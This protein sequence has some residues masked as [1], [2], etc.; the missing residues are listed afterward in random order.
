M[1]RKLLLADDSVTIQKVVE[2]ILSEDDFAITTVSDG[3]E[4][5]ARM[6]DVKPDIVLADVDMPK[7]GG[8]ELCKKIKADPATRHI[9]VLLLAGAFE[10]IDA[11]KVKEAGAVDY[12]VKPFESQDLINKIEG[13]FGKLSGG[14]EEAIE[15]GPQQAAKGKSKAPVEETV[16]EENK[17]SI[18]MGRMDSGFLDEGQ[19]LGF[20]DSH[21][22]TREL[23][24]VLSSIS[25]E[26]EA[27]PKGE[28]VEELED[29]EELMAV[30][31]EKAKEDAQKAKK[32][33]REE[34]TAIEGGESSGVLNTEEP[35]GGADDARKKEGTAPEIGATAM[36]DQDDIQKLLD[37][38]GGGE[39]Q[40]GE[41]DEGLLRIEDEIDP[42]PGI[43]VL[44]AEEPP[45]GDALVIEELD[46]LDETAGGKGRAKTAPVEEK[47]A[48]RRPEPEP[49][50]DYETFEP[51]APR[52]AAAGDVLITVSEVNA[53]IKN[54]LSRKISH[55]IN[56]EKIYAVFKDAVT[57]Y[58]DGNF[59]DMRSDI[60]GMFDA[61]VNGKI[62]R[63]VSQV[64]VE[65]IVNQVISS[66][67][68][69]VLGDLVNEIFKAARESAER[70]VKDLVEA[71]MPSIRGEMEK[72][73][74]KTVPEAAERLIKEEIEQIKSDFM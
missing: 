51:V 70:Y 42:G 23:K 26:G 30:L 66:T 31:A 8:F 25:D 68:K 5:L 36:M 73:V 64:K 35:Q 52:T 50:D 6:G 65:T 24:D 21:L 45:H 1:P 53:L 3:E 56:D 29:S 49:E 37:E 61:A 43:D 10:P 55:V 59:T 13:I 69:T 12:I 7:L 4:A 9:P 74:W 28:E 15:L 14:E 67:I 58:I 71:K 44:Q 19:G 72:A 34:E 33:L 39:K 20:D 63:L 60:T 22:T 17:D 2:L 47:P 32:A 62:D 16:F 54:A 27:A 38:A 48:R 11:K 40:P 41:K 57:Q 18:D 46:I